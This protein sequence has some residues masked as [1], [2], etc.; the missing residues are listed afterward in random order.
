MEGIRIR[1]WIGA[2]AAVLAFAPSAGSAQGA[3]APDTRPTLAVMYFTN[4]ALLRHD[5]YAPLSKGIAEML[6]TELSSNTKVRVV[7]RDQLQ[8]LLQEQNLGATDRVDKETAVRLGKVL[9]ARHFLMGGF[10]ID[11]KENVRLDVRAVNVETSQIDH[12]ESVSGKAENLLALISEMGGKLNAGLKLPAIPPAS[13]PAANTP[14]DEGSAPAPAGASP[15]SGTASAGIEVTKEGGRG[16][17]PQRP[18]APAGQVSAASSN[19]KKVNQVRAVLLLGRAL[20]AKDRG[21]N[22]AAV[23]NY[24]AAIETYPEFG[25]AKVLMASLERR[26]QGT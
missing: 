21:N 1:R 25:R 7:E 26:P 20:E 24:R 22:E 23:A 13:R 2:A 18:A 11:P 14:R 15:A 6:I 10:V 8:A 5:E 9:G 19:G 4:A 17:A 3:T 12:V 16:R